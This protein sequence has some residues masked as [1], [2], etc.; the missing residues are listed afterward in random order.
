MSLLRVA[1]AAACATALATPA[2]SAHGGGIIKAA[3]D[4]LRSGDPL[5]VDA[6]A[7]PTL[8]RDEAELLRDR[9]AAAG[10]IYVAVLPADAQHE[11]TTA[12]KVLAAVADGLALEGTYAVSVGGQLRATSM[13]IEAG[14]AAALGRRAAARAETSGLGAALLE[15]VAA[16]QTESGEGESRL[17]TGVAAALIPLLAVLAVLATLVRARRRS[18][19]G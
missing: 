9:L 10:N 5:Y 14:R 6:N 19:V 11:L 3:L 15:F 2:A 18:S 8:E 16:V 1:L 4:G 13:S 7:I 12:D 17:S